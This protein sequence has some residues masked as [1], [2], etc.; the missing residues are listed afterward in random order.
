MAT[1]EMR[2]IPFDSRKQLAEDG[3]TYEDRE[4]FSADIA[5]YFGYLSSN[6]ICIHEGESLNNQLKITAGTAGTVIF[7]PGAIKIQGRMGWMEEAVEKQ[8]E[9]GGTK[10][11]YDTAVIEL[12]LSTAER[13]FI[14]KIIKGEE[15]D[16]PTPPELTQ[17]ANIYQLGLANIYRTANS[18][19]LG[20]IKDTRADAS[21]CGISKVIVPNLFGAITAS[22]LQFLT[23][24]G[25]G[26]TPK[27]WAT[28]GSRPVYIGTS[29]LLINQPRTYGWL[30]NYTLGGEL[31]AQQFI[32]MD[33]N[34]PVYYRSGNAKGWYPGSEN[35]VRSLDEN[36]GVQ[37]KKV[38]TNASPGSDF[39]EQMIQL[40]V[41]GAS[42]ILVVFKITK[43]S[44]LWK[45]AILTCDGNSYIMDA[46]YNTDY[47]SG[48]TVI[49][50]AFRGATCQSD[51]IQFG[52]GY[53]KDHSDKNSVERPSFVIPIKMFVVK[54]A[55]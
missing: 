39:P 25:N 48:G 4:V 18:T 16:T 19:A 52:K 13:R 51:G 36:N 14:P 49:G 43:S 38:W 50:T 46:P 34:S 31:I 45:V 8:A 55:I 37:I 21:R 33:G 40:N 42:F 54:G 28:V 24:G 30:Y 41:T 7:N 5:E 2:G 15:S 12:N 11:R 10:P 47:A 9:A 17:T 3:S 20:T 32:A 35:W 1:E 6:G 27:N 29:N 44:N 53:S 26:D 22:E 23:G